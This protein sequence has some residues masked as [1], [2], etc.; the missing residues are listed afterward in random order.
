MGILRPVWGKSIVMTEPCIV[1]NTKNLDIFSDIRQ[2]SSDYG[3]MSNLWIGKQWQNVLRSPI[4]RMKNYPNKQNHRSEGWLVNLFHPGWLPD[5]YYHHMDSMNLMV[6]AYVV[7][8]GLK[9]EWRWVH[10]G[11]IEGLII[12]LHFI[13]S[14][15]LWYKS[16]II[17]SQLIFIIIFLKTPGVFLMFPKKNPRLFVR[18]FCSPTKTGDFGAPGGTT[19]GLGL[20]LRGLWDVHL[21]VPKIR[22]PGLVKGWGKLNITGNP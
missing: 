10:P 8:L 14:S 19:R 7:I 6:S 9:I 3:W 5:G 16:T 18:V 17:T 11:F 4:H 1:S 21:E 15:Q 12:V 20:W 2:N 13:C 22:P